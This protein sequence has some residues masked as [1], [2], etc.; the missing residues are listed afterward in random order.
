[1]N[2]YFFILKDLVKKTLKSRYAST[3]L[4]IFWAVLSPVLIMIAINL[5]FIKFLNI[6]FKNYH[7]F[8]LCGILPWLFVS[9]SISE[10]LYSLISNLRLLPQVRF[11]Y[12]CFPIATALVEFVEHCLALVFLIPVF[13]FYNLKII[14]YL[15]LIIFLLFFMA[16]FVISLSIIFSIL[17]IYFKDIKHFL[18]VGLMFWFWMTPIFYLPQMIPERYRCFVWINP[19]SY[20]ITIYRDILFYGRLSNMWIW[21]G[22]VG[23]SIFSFAF[24]FILFNKVKYDLVKRI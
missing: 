4:G 18:G 14:K 20:F 10:S 16:L 21:I 13:I 7:I 3:F 8:V 19:L 2:S 11:P 12:I 9:S 24:S 6:D 23:I 1:M 15:P 5:I 17:N 22:I